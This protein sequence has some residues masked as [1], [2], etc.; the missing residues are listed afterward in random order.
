M[1]IAAN[2]GFVRQV[3]STNYTFPVG[4]R[5]SAG[6]RKKTSPSF[7]DLYVVFSESIN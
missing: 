6:K 7:H 1:K 4:I 5:E 3:V 2:A